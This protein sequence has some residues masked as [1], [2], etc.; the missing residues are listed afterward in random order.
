M[1]FQICVQSCPNETWTYIVDV[2]PLEAALVDNSGNREVAANA[3]GVDWSKYI[4]TYGFNA[5]EEFING[6]VNN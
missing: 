3:S 2:I 5:R 6:M 1:C 4:C